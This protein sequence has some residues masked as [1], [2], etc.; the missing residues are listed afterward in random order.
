M[1]CCTPPHSTSPP[2]RP[3]L[4]LPSLPVL[5]PIQITIS[6]HRHTAGYSAQHGSPYLG[7]VN[8]LNLR[9]LRRASKTAEKPPHIRMA[10]VNA[11]SL[12]NKTFILNDF[13]CSHRLD[14][15]CIT[16]T[17]LNDEPSPFS[18]LVP[19]NCGFFNSP[20]TT[21]RG[22]GLATVFNNKF[23]CRQLRSDPFS[24]FELQL[25]ELSQS[26]KILCALLYRP[27]KPNTNFISELSEFLADIVLHYDNILILGD[28]NIHVCCPSKPM[29]NDFL[30]LIN[31]FN[32]EQLATGPTHELGHT[33]DLVLS[34]GITVNLCKIYDATFSDH[35]PVTFQVIIPDLVVNTT[36]PDRRTRFITP[37]TAEQFTTA[38]RDSSLF[39]DLHSPSPSLNAANILTS[40]N[41]T[42]SAILDTVAPLTSY[43]PKFKSQPWLNE[44]TRSLRQQCRRAERKWKKDKLRVSHG[45]LKDC[46]SNYQSAV[47]AAR[48]IYYSDL[49]DK[50]CHRPRILFRVI[51][52]VINPPALI[53]PNLSSHMCNTFL[54]FFQNKITELRSHHI[55]HNPDPVS[56]QPPPL[57]LD[58]FEPVLLPALTVIVTKLKPTNC[59]SDII[60][61]KLFKDIFAVIGPSI[62]TILNACL[63]TGSVPGYFKHATVRPLLKK[64]NM[65]P[66]DPSNFRP[67]STL[68]FMSKVLEKVV[69][70]QLQSFL[71]RNG[72]CEVFQSG[73]KSHHSTET[74]LLRVFNDLLLMTDAGDSAVLVLL[75]LTAAFDTVDHEILISR[76]E[77]YVGIRGT[78]LKWFRSYLSD[79]TFCVS[80][81]DYFSQSAPLTS[82]V[83]QGSILGPILFSIYMLPLGLIFKRHKVGYHF[84]ADDTQIYLPLNPGT[85]SINTLIH[86]LSDVKTWLS[87]NFLSLNENKTEILVLNPSHHFPM[88]RDNIPSLLGPLAP[89]SKSHTKNLG[90]TFDS[91]FKLDSQINSVVK[92]SFYQLKVLAKLKPFLSPHDLEKVTHAF[93]SSRLDYCN[94]L[95]VGVGQAQISRL[96]L[97]QNAAARLLTGTRKRDHISPVL[98]SLHWLPVPY[99]IHF[100][101]LLTVYK[102]LNGLAPPYLT[103]LIHPYVPHRS[104]RSADQ[105]L[106]FVPRS[107]LVLRADRAFSVAAPK[108]WNSLPLH[109]RLETSLPAFKSGLKTHL[110]TLAFMTATI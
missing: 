54:N 36:A 106:L 16:E 27:P 5:F 51:N 46:L 99:R 30:N 80:T 22:G 49:I 96:Q 107:S 3:K 67:I 103:E 102:C 87:Q 63:E 84:Y 98:A 50:H 78:A 6:H 61:S 105:Q 2:F 32:F 101:L 108:L 72:I 23:Y 93:I 74:A 45:I 13:F 60:P 42:C 4:C 76:L 91:S 62:L 48:N 28:F 15:L 100:K 35:M 59:S 77:Q 17:W 64:P 66:I 88:S 29:V 92:A 109:I 18:E 21:G 94:S 31:S 19:P 86:C 97:I 55:P 68:P 37:S 104:L 41:A 34:T 26:T 70:Q 110:F 57:V 24:S 8:L 75:D 90:V 39:H 95:Y 47:K 71:M 65:D 14:F 11:R 82:G 53:C 10:L 1:T 38:F 33:L 85:D 9:P 81:G 52:A 69:L 25:F 40:F 12:A 58:Q 89:Y 83:P 73:F 79:R 43:R 7:G 20:R 56:L 44:T